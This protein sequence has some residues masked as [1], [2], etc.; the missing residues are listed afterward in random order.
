MA[1]GF[2][3]LVF[4]SEITQHPGSLRCARLIRGRRRAKEPGAQETG[5]VGDPPAFGH[6][7]AHEGHQARSEKRGS[8]SFQV[9]F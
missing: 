2:L 4:G 1:V 5:F 3:F 8:R 7:D 9:I 6:I